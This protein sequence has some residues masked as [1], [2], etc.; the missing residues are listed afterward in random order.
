MNPGGPC[1]TSPPPPRPC[2]CWYVANDIQSFCPPL[3][4][5]P[6]PPHPSRLFLPPRPPPA[7]VPVW[8]PVATPENG[9]VAGIAICCKGGACVVW[10]EGACGRCANDMA[11]T[12]LICNII[13]IWLGLSWL[14]AFA[15]DSGTAV[16]CAPVRV[17]PVVIT[18][19]LRVVVVPP[20]AVVAS[21]LSLSAAYI[22]WVCGAYPI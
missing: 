9:W 2:L 18:A 15:I 10:K 14:I 11:A 22:L 5:A 21:L 4:P 13:A 7:V 16:V 1:C 3:R 12:W 19:A 20:V 6:R 8:K 17:L